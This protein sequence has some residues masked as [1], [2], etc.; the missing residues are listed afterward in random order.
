MDCSPKLTEEK[1]FAY[2]EGHRTVETVL[3]LLFCLIFP[4][5]IL[6]IVALIITD[7]MNGI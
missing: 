2:W 5:I 4:P 6:G 3:C 1:F 7:K